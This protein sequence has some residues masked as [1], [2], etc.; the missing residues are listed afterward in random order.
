MDS[1]GDAPGANDD[2]SG[3]ATVIECARI[4]SKQSFSATIIFVT[5]SGEEQGLLGANFMATKAKKENWQILD[6]KK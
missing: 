4:M 1:T 6:L 5:V 3:C 2:A